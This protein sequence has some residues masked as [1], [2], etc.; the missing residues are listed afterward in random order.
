[1][2]V[3]A[4][5][6][7]SAGRSRGAG[8]PVGM[9]V[10]CITTGEGKRQDCETTTLITHTLRAEGF[11]ASEDGTGRGTPLVPVAFAHQQGGS[12]DL[13]AARD[14]ALTLQRNQTQAVAF[15]QAEGAVNT[16]DI[17]YSIAT[18][19]GKPGVSYPAIPVNSA[20]RRLTPREC[21][22]LQGFPDDWTLVPHRGKPAADG[23]RYKALGN[24]MAVPVLR[25]IGERIAAVDALRMERAA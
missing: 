6:M 13:H 11:D 19:G 20:V 8:T 15:W 18:G 14:C 22:R 21:D 3:A 17:A 25:W 10:R 9:L 4:T 1:L 5:L 7:A 12:M 16:A 2:I 23:P 24:S